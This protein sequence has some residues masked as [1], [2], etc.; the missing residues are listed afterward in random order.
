MKKKILATSLALTMSLA[1]VACGES[2]ISNTKTG[3]SIQNTSTETPDTP[4]QDTNT[5]TAQGQFA[6]K[7]VANGEFSY[8]HYYDFMLSNSTENGIF[9][10]ESMNSAFCLYSELLEDNDKQTIQDYIGNRSYLTYQSSDS[11]KTLNRLWVNENKEFDANINPII[12]D[13]NIQYKLNTNDS[14]AATKEK[15][16]Y[17]A[18]NT[19]NFITST[20]TIFD[21]ETVFDAMNVVYFK[22]SWKNGD[23]EMTTDNVTFHNDNQTTTDIPMMLDY[24]GSVRYTKNAHS[25]TMSYED[26]FKFTVI[27]PD[28]GY[29]LKD[30]DLDAFINGDTEYLDCTSSLKIPEFETTSTYLA[31]PDNFGLQDGQIKEEIYKYDVDK[32]QISQVAKIKFDRKGTEA[33]AV[34]EICVTEALEAEPPEPY[35]MVCD[36]PFAYYITDTLNDDIAFI[37]FVKNIE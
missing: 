4:N 27:L 1:L 9:S 3:S 31:T 24:D 5:T 23:K 35:H 15:N 2:T 37:G 18:K 33:A 7:E 16:D 11:F 36:K 29:E 34:S 6:A 26:G 22:D 14:A 30:I 21:S 13:N 28:D 25:Y 32:A 10:P 20:P 12:K 19:N 8:N 17:V